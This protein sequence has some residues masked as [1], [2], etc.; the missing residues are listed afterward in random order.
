[1]G[2]DGID[3]DELL[4]QVQAILCLAQV[5]RDEED[6]VALPTSGLPS[7]ELIQSLQDLISGLGVLLATTFE[8][9]PVE[10]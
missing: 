5:R 2:E 6:L 7:Q 3:R 1:M 4:A 9:A 10:W 8:A